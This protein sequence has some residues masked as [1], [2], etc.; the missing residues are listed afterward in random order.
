MIDEHR[1]VPDS[2]SVGYMHAMNLGIS[3][4][5]EVVP[6]GGVGA[7]EPGV[8]IPTGVLERVVGA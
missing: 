6:S 1:V 5:V 2:T 7:E 4:A 3:D 8:L